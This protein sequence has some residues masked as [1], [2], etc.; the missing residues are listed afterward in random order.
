VL[1]L[2]FKNVLEI[3][4]FEKSA[5]TSKNLKK[6]LK[7]SEKKLQIFFCVGASTGG[8]KISLI[9]KACLMLNFLNLKSKASHLFFWVASSLSILWDVRKYKEFCTNLLFCVYLGYFSLVS[10]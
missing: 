3:S 2:L 1:I 5:K 8:H 9:K 10:R 6:P 7:N 4:N